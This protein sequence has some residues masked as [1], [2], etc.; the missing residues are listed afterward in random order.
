[1]VMLAPGIDRTPRS[2]DIDDNALDLSYD[3]LT[4]SYLVP[5]FISEAIKY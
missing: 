5:S 4:K 3:D 1:M 2:L